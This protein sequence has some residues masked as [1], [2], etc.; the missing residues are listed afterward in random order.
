LEQGVEEGVLRNDV[1]VDDLQIALVGPLMLRS[2]LKQEGRE[3]S[4]EALL[5]IFW[6]GAKQM[7]E[8]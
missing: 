8:E 5:G 3:V 2:R 7:E 1:S 4:L 6:S